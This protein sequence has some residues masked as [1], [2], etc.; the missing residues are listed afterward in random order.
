M[1]TPI[2]VIGTACRFPGDVASPSQLWDLLSNPKDVLRDPDPNRLN[3]SSFHH[4]SGEHHGAT[5]VPN[6]SYILEE[7]IH[8]FDAAF[9][10]ISAAEAE[11]MDPQQR[12][13]LETT[14]EALEG[15]GYTLK[16][17]RGSSTSVFIGAMTSDYH[18]IQ[19]RDLDT[20]SR[21]HATGT[22]PSILSNR[23]SYFFDLKGPSMTINTACSS[24]LVALHQAV[25]SLRDGDCTAAIVGG[26]NLLLDPEVYI[27]HSN[28][29]MLSPTSR[30]R[31]W[32]RDADGYARG[33]GCASI[34][35]K[36]LDQA[37]KDGDDVECIIRETAVNSDGRS[38]GITMPSPEAQATL[39]REAYERSGLDPVRDRCQY[40]ECHGTGTQAG[41]PVEA[42][43]IQQTFYPKNAVFSPHDKLYVGSIKT[44]I[45]HLEGCAGL[46]GL[47]K[48]IMCLKNRTITPNM[49]FDNLNPNI[50]P[51]YDH[52]S[53]PTNTMPWPPVAHG[54]P[55]RASVNSFGFGGTNAH[56]IV[57]SYVS[58]QPKCQDSYCKE[59]NPKKYITSGPFVFSAH[60][61]ESL[62][63][64]IERTA[65]Y[66]R[67]NEALDLGH[68]AW[69]LAKR[70]VLP[71]KVAITALS[72]EE[73]LENIDKVIENYKTSKPSGPSQFL[74]KHPPEPHRIMGIFTGQG[75][76][77]A[78][79]GRELLLA[80][81]I[82]RKSIERCERALANLHD[83]PSWSLQ[84]E[85]LADKPSSRLSNPAISQPVT[86]AI[87]IA[88]YDLLCACGVNVDVVVGHSSGEIV[89]AYA[90]NIISAEDCMKIAYYRGLHTKSMR[91]GGMLAVGLSFPDASE[92]CSQRSFSGRIVV[93]ASNGPAS[94][95]LSGD[96]DAILEVKALLEYN[97]TFAR[98]LQV[99]V[100][101]HSHHMVP[102]SA[103]YLESLR[104]CNIQV[105]SP[106]SG[107]TW[108][109]S[110]T[111]RNAILDGDIQSFSAT[112]WVDNMVKPVLF[113]QALERSLCDN[114]DLG[115]CIEFGPHPA[116]RGPVLD[117]LKSKGASSVLYTSL[118]HR[119]QNDLK[120]A[121]SAISYLWERMADGIDL[122]RFLQGFRSQPLQLIKGLPA[123]SWD[124]GRKY[125]R[126]SRI[127]RR[128]RL[129]GTQ[130]HPLLGRRSAD[131]FPNELRWKNILHIKEMPW[132]QGYKEE[133]KVVLSAAFY[134]S[135]LLSAASSAPVCQRL[136]L[137]ELNNFVVMEPIT[138]EEYGNGVEYITTIRF[139]NE[140]F[141]RTLNTRLDA[142]ASC[143]ACNSDESVLTKLCTARLT[144]HLSDASHPDCD[145][146]PRRDQRSDLLAPVDV[147]DLYDSFEEAGMRYSGLFRSIT[148]IQ[149]SLGEATASVAWAEDKI[150]PKSIIHPA[151]VEASFQ[152]M[153]CAF[154][155]P[156]TQELRTPFHA[157][158]VRRVLI[159]PSLALEGVSC[160]IDAFVT[161]VDRDGIEGDVSLYKPDGNA[162]IQIEGLV[163]KNI[164]QP[165]SSSDRNLFSHVVWE[166]DPFGYSLIPYP[167]PKESMGW[168]RAADIVALYHFQRAV[169][170]IDPLESAGFTPHHQLL[171]REISRIAA[172]GRGS[173]YY[174]T[175]PDCAKM[176]EESILAMIQKFAGTADLQ[177]LHS[178]GKALPAI[179][180]DEVDLLNRPNEPDT[181]EGFTQ[182]TGMF[183][184]LSKDICC[185]VRRIVHKHPH[186][187]VLEL[188]NGNSAITQQILEAL[189]DKYTSYGLGSTDPVLLN[190]TVA[191]LSAQHRNVYSK[192]IDLT[193]DNAGEHAS[194][195]YD[196]IIAANPLH[197]TDTSAN[198]FEVCRAMLKPGGYLVFVRLTGRMPVSLL[199]T[200]GWL[201]QWWQG[202]D[203]DAQTWS[204]MSTVRYD[205]QLRSKGFS[206]IDHI[207]HGSMN[208]N[209]DG[210]S[211]MVTQ[212]VNDTV[213]ML[214]E[215]MNSTG[216]APLTETVV[217]VGGKT[218]SVARVLQSIQR[219]LA[220]SGTA[221]A[222]VED[223][224]RLELNGLT[225]QH[226]IISLVELDKPFF[227]RG[228]FHERLLAFKELVG[229]CKH[230]LWLTTG[231]M[232]SIS[233]AIGRAIRSERG[234]D[235][236]LQF[237]DLSTMENISPSAVVEVFL[238]LTWSFVPVLTDGQVLWTNEPELQWDGCTLR[239]PRLVPDHKRNKR[240]SSRHRQGRLKAGLP[241]TSV[242]LSPNVSA[243]SVAVQ[244]QYSC[245]VCTDVYLWV[246]ARVDGKG[247]IVGISDHV[248]SIIQARP[249]RVHNLS[250]KHDLSPDG[251]R[252]TAS[253]T[254]ACL[255]MKSLSGPILLYEPGELLVAAVEQVREPEQTIHFVTSNYN[256]CKKGWIAVH[257]HASR[258]MVE[259]MLP[260]KVSAFVDFSSGDDDVVTTLRDIY[261]H[262]RIQAVELYRRAFAASPGQLIA[263]SYAQACTSLSTLPHTALEVTSSTE[264]STNVALVAYPKVVN[265]MSPS[266]ISNQGD[267]ISATTMFSSSGTY[268]MVD[269]AT[270]LGFSILK[271]MATNGART[272]V[273]ASRNPRMHGAWLEEMSRL[274]ATVK[275]L[276][277]DVS[278]KE[279]ILSAFSQIKEAL[280]PI[281][282]VCYAPLAL[283]DQGFEYTVEDA[284]GLA[285]T[286]MINAA[287]YLDELFP[288][289]TLDF[290]VILTSLV[291]VIGTPKQV[292]Y[293][294]PSLFMT[295]LIQRRRM[296]GLV[297]SVMA[298]GMVVD[299]GYF[300]KQGKEV[301]QRM[302]HHGYAP[303]SESDLHHAFG[304]VVAA[305]APEAE[306]NPEIFFGLQMID[307]QI[308]QSR[309]STSVSNRLLSHFIT[310]RSGTTEGQY[311]EQE[312]SAS[313]LVPDEQLEESGL[314][315]NAYDNLLVRLSV[316]VRSILRLGD[317]AL[318]VHT[319]LLDL[320][321]DSLLAMDIQAW[322]AKEFDI[323]ITPM[324]ALL[325]TV[326]GLCEKAVP[327]ANAPSL[328]LEKE[329][330]LVKALDFIDVATTA[331]RSEHSSSVQDIPLDGTSSESSCVLC[332]SDSG[333]EQVRNE[334]EPRFTRIENM[335][336]H[337]SQIWF[338]GHW[339]RD[340]TQYNVV[341][342]YN[343]EGR[344]PVHRFKQALE[345]TVSMHESLRTAFFSDPN[346]GDLLQGVL[347]VPP[348]FF[349][350]VRTSSAAS[351]SQ[352]FDK[353]ASYQ[354]RLEDGEVM[355]VT[356]VSV[357]QDQHTVIFG[358]HHIVMD[359]ASWSTFL[360]DLKCIYE[361]R[362]PREVAQ[363]V[364]YSLM[365]N[366][367]IHNGTFAKELEFW[368]SE[369]LPPPEM[370]PVLPLAKEKTR[371]P[372]DNFKV[373][374]STRHVSIEA[375]ERIKQASRSLRGT[376][377]HFYLATLQVFL[378][379]L[380][381]IKSLCIG[382]SD[383]NRKHQHFTGTVGYFLN[384][385][386]LRFEVQQTD[387]F[388]NVFQK[389]SSK[390]LTALLNSS[391]PSNL[392]VDEL[393]I[394]RVSNV[395]P[396]FQVAINYRVGEITRMS[397]DDFDLNYDRSIMGNAPYDISFHIT[398]CANGTS[399]VEVNCRDY[400][401][402]P[403]ATERIIDEYVRLLEIMSSDP[404]Q[405]AQSSVA[406]SAPINEDGLSVQRGP[407]ISH[408]WPATLPERFED[409]VD[410]YGDRIAVTDQG[411]DFSYLQLQAQSTRIGEALLQ[412]GVRS[413]DTVAVLCP[414]SMS[415]VASML[416]ILQ[417]NAVYVPLD[418][419]LPAAR[420]KAMILASPVRALVCV[421]STVEKVP[422]LGVSTILNLS[423]IP[424]IRAPP[425]RFTNSA[426]GDSLSILLYTSGSTGQPKG[427]CLPQSGFINYLAAKRKE[428]SLDSSTVV[429]QQSSLGF[430]MG[431]AQTLNAIMNGG[432]L[433]I[434]PQELRGDSI[435]IARIIRDQKVTFT[436]ATP[437]EYLVMLQHGR[438]YLHN[439]AGWRHACLGGEPF[440][441][442]LKREF[443]R[444]GKNCP[445]VQDSYGVTEISACTT[446]ETMS[447]SQLEEARSVGRTIPNTSLYIVDVDCNLVATGEPGEICI[448]GA[449]VALGYLNEEQTRLKF[450]QDPFALP[451]DIARGWTRM[452][453]TGDKAKLL[454]DGSLILM[455][456]MDGNTEIKVRGLRIDLE[457]V[458]STMVNCH[459]DLLSSAIVCVKGQGVS[460]TLVAF[461]ALMPGQTASDV[462]LQHLASNLPLPQYMR[463]STVICLD[464][465]PRNAN[466]KIDRK[467]IDAM[468]WTT[469]TTFSQPSKRLT[470]GE[471]E[472]KLLWQVL[473]P[474]KHIQPESD[475]FLLGG[476][477]TLLVRLQGA[478]RTSIGVSLTLREM[479][480]ASTLAQMAL[481]VNARKAESPSMTIN[482]LAETAIPQ[483]L[484]D[485]ASSTSSINQHKHCQGSGCQILLT[486]STSF[487]GRVLVQLL[488]Q[489]P[490][491]D[492]VHCIAVEKEQEHVLPTS[493]KVSLYYGNL[494]DPNLGLSTAEWAS[495]QDRIDVVIHNGSNGHCL[496]TYNSLK[497]PNLGSTHRLAE[498]ALQSQ[499]PL[500]YISSGRVILQSGQTALGPTSV[501]F[502][503]PPLDGSDGLTATKWASEVFLERLAE[504]TGISISIH[505]PCTPIGDQAPAQDALNS[506]LRYS[507]NLG[508]TPRLTRMEGYLDFQ[509]VE[510]IAEEIATLVTS[511]FTKRSNTLSFTTSGVS[512]FHHSS[513]IKV[514]VKSFKE[515]MEKVHGR[516]FQ[517]LS[518]REW[519]SL[520]LEQGIEP[521]IPS[522][523]E[524]VDDNE[525]TLRYPYLGTE[526]SS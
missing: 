247:N 485:R 24:S 508:A 32:D 23:I 99:D 61:Q 413:G 442:Q 215:P 14:Y 422:E 156:F 72:R 502:H 200:C 368:K 523:L 424:D 249:D 495:L 40:F 179:L 337:Q 409:M 216:L 349:E 477:S 466:G 210:L 139:H 332:P 269:M 462:E 197:A 524:A 20:I 267:M 223:I 94:T 525:E 384:M 515:Y 276:K 311:A 112:Y 261:S 181:L 5:D 371:I 365:L 171:Y 65:R 315:K 455:G 420:H 79:M 393:N 458:A 278:N 146:L 252:A 298:L 254:L 351:V 44:L 3:L 43:A 346:N 81:S 91:P 203:H 374:T 250:D 412:K 263:D 473:L 510:I 469:P 429:L 251:L 172:V 290:F 309:V 230:V 457:D 205:S 441:D 190:Q 194:D 401:Y 9:F 19:A 431:L 375:T 414:P 385:L 22:S 270:P 491:V 438:E 445:V 287:K 192:V 157:K 325:D 148:S 383:A 443:V 169:D 428:L 320:G 378:A 402:S 49:F 421:S 93:A 357:G 461:V 335:S 493:D 11:A 74:W 127:S 101:Y 100:A 12:L 160:D 37:L 266:P 48:A 89:A 239:I 58:S 314:G 444:L 134:L 150:I 352:E 170:E 496:N 227:S 73:L 344:F 8:R 103:A 277:M 152:A 244:V 350:H 282:G 6:K 221:T 105:K 129:E 486:G 147:A 289:P 284:G 132:A 199:C 519:S 340:P 55:L 173:E 387:S 145:Q 291:S 108:I 119:G 141:R 498:F 456:R 317:Q 381:K 178:L 285:A 53:V 390:V 258:R 323:D 135:S 113:S 343:V 176:S 52:L 214:R 328:V 264:V 453:R 256:N 224:D 369:L 2:A 430:D 370:M 183:S 110:V 416:A 283:S 121:S 1:R 204:D 367:D 395:T 107:C 115:A 248:S 88:I 410:Q 28:L 312:D 140:H 268:W 63:S 364:D 313:L 159:T 51:F 423:E 389:T 475:F 503:P 286:A 184:Q 382:M 96:Y 111:G 7:D 504:H 242:P 232:T 158:E 376:P 433:V 417:I 509:K 130:L 166:S 407:R 333:F 84:E 440:T 348:P 507:V 143:Y 120:A 363:Y 202:Y 411:R 361:Q 362:P 116:L 15:A 296:R 355:R 360:H 316:K 506:L 138:L 68:L 427:V 326:A 294:A 246:G 85:L 16:Q 56:A 482:W 279:S 339:M 272:F 500:H 329:D 234:A 193:T 388:A 77:W 189:D 516:P 83:G 476:N 30:C 513:N 359:G 450:V 38:A 273:L 104:A 499:V 297:G 408:G 435:E 168:K 123:Y 66:V 353:L 220:A 405:S 471:G 319:P 185:I 483:N 380:L 492:R 36:T 64:I 404:L 480:G 497:G 288:T 4:H 41:D 436:L 342:S 109:S 47:M 175:D 106:R 125:W 59:S 25:Q 418:L 265:W 90:L 307:S 341:I 95:T 217:L 308:D 128:Y 133:G 69:T 102:C 13:L 305:G 262:A 228:V 131:E 299:A 275:P 27:S 373:H 448:S 295:D 87:E 336:P 191:R 464:E 78:G 33:E 358:Y 281:V 463:P 331:S 487:L 310:S 124:H 386:P 117:T 468:P 280:P 162:I 196:M 460:E 209:G 479:Y 229:R 334:L 439:Y 303:L 321:C 271:W 432:K 236:S 293:H 397:V 372:T 324:D 301:I 306:G 399:I 396:L 222:V 50:T 522:F 488:L 426:K 42:Q 300:A 149:R 180:R 174:I 330:Q 235:V 406:T 521:L 219:T 167:T 198:L 98:T 57:E 201:P 459:P 18:D 501:S 354:W 17:M 45:G 75:A 114:Q 206:G 377:F 474:G 188:N 195:K 511:R 434:V 237:L 182:G 366:R 494:L 467:R 70:T 446:F 60:T 155:S 238:R 292:A 356:V 437:S 31:M 163:M 161:G 164:P 338:A 21:W 142:E 259:R 302:M 34:V 71:F 327:R 472:L 46:A 391:I 211:V 419:S 151:L 165:E 92:L 10:N 86:T 518:L 226:S 347:K 304:E 241:Q 260:R 29:H 470:L 126:E 489:V 153:M 394:P 447:V 122:A 144:L 213:M 186:M 478:I 240:Y 257:P 526:S 253:F 218:L 35:I 345:Q 118:L 454:D 322:V 187:D 318:D 403:E 481:K 400:L 154:A 490:E 62:Y 398:P 136:V 517:E 137:F 415:S 245:L 465:L 514:P 449:G 39:I 208:S 97:K 76:Q 520:A 484:L 451:D 207:F 80:S 225:K 26:V 425:T 512:F 231:D 452:Y 274:G 212:A 82:F 177:S 505:R 243:N 233:V 67:S 379:G 54:C 392:V 255:L